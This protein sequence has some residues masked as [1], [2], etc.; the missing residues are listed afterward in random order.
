ME[1][2]ILA[3]NLPLLSKEGGRRN[4]SALFLLFSIKSN[5]SNIVAVKWASLIARQPLGESL[6]IAPSTLSLLDTS[7]N[8]RSSSKLMSDATGLKE[9]TNFKALLWYGTKMFSGS[10]W[11]CNY[12]QSLFFNS[13]LSLELLLS[14]PASRF[15]NKDAE[16]KAFLFLSLSVFQRRKCVEYVTASWQKE[17]QNF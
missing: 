7:G 14:S 4:F 5:W 6:Y 15:P 12:S 10:C 13:N 1:S 9:D 16:V 8:W 2:I 17:M 11:K 3:Y